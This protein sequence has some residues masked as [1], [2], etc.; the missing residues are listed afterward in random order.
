VFG[1]GV[2]GAALALGAVG[3]LATSSSPA[4]AQQNHSPATVTATDAGVPP[5][6][7]AA[8]QG[9][10]TPPDI[11]DVEHMCAL[12]TSC[13]NLPLPPEALPSS[14]P[15]CVQSAMSVLT[16]PDALKFPL[17]IR[18]CGLR[19]NSCNELRTCAL[20]GVAPD[21][22]KGHGKNGRAGQCDDDG[23][24]I[25]CSHEKVVGVRDC[26]RGG[27]QCIVRE[28]QAACVL[29]PC[30]SENKEGSP[31]SCSASGTRVLQCEHGKL[32]SL[33]CAVLGLKCTMSDGKPGCST[34]TA[35]CSGT[36][37]H[38]DGNVSVGC[39]HGHEVRVDC[40]A[41]GLTCNATPGAIPV[42]ACVAQ[43]PESDKC[44][45]KDPPKC[46]GATIK[47]CFAGKKRSYFCKS[48]G[49]NGC[50]KD[51]SSVHCGG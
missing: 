34:P 33:D 9:L 24:A 46:D 30:T 6:I 16:S 39:M 13:P 18:E 51:G 29:G 17:V 37:K 15:G 36:S 25:N 2:F 43:P 12:L 19:S 50:V 38:C 14:V 31:P 48:L 32:S 47:Y 3:V 4:Q 26:T 10:V 27:E 5:Y 35:T 8:G 44:D 20:R 28:G 49:F 42:G 40:G 7:V 11:E 1:S 23:R 45:P 21:I 41:S 22:C